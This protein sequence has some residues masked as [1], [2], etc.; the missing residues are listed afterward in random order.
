MKPSDLQ[1]VA[2]WKY[3]GPAVRQLV[4]VNSSA[5]VEE[6]SRVSFATDSERLRIGALMTLHGVAGP[7][8]SVILHFIFPDRYPV[9]DK[10][11]MRTIGAPIA[12]QFDRWLQYGAFCRRACKHYGVTLRALDEALW[13][14]DYERRPGD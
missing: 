13:Q 5:D 1:E 11:V 14:Y 7:M 2:R 3:P 6:I 8:A 10:R 9:L 12:Y 4:A